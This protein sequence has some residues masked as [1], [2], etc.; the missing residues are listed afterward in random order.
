MPQ[1][2]SRPKRSF[3]CSAIIIPQTMM[4]TKRKT[5]S[6]LNRKPKFLADH[7]KNEIGVRVGQVEHFLA[8]VAEAEPFD[9]AAAPG[10]QRLHLLQ[11][12]VLF[13]ALGIDESASSRPMRS[14]MW[15]AT[16]KIPPMP[17]DREHA[18]QD[19]VRP[20][21]EHHHERG[22]ADQRGRAEIDFDD[23]Q[24]PAAQLTTP[25]E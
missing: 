9:S 13:V 1:P 23:D 6:K 25:A 11:A 8:A 7:R 16:K 15:V 2:S 21:D 18:E 19:R 24:E 22:R 10:D 14:G 4:T 17:H 3:A 12:G 20:G 5:T